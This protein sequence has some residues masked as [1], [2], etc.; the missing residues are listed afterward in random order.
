[1]TGVIRPRF[2]RGAGSQARRGWR[3]LAD[4]QAQQQ[5]PQQHDAKGGGQHM[6]RLARLQTGSRRCTM[7]IHQECQVEHATAQA[8]PTARLGAW[9]RATLVMPVASS[10]SEVTLAI[11]VKPIQLPESPVRR[12]MASPARESW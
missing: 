2:Q 4:Q 9:A 8:L 5:K 12:A 10:G 7:S 11:S 1:M 3:E 6:A